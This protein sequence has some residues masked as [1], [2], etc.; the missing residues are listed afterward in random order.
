MSKG[1]GLDLGVIMHVQRIPEETSQ[2]LTEGRAKYVFVLTAKKRGFD[3][4]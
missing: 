4:F 3:I 2:E 1:K